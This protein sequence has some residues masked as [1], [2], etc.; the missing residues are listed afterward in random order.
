LI[1]TPGEG[2]REGKSQNESVGGDKKLDSSTK[3]KLNDKPH[4]GERQNRKRPGKGN[5]KNFQ[6]VKNPD[7]EKVYRDTQRGR[8]PYARGARVWKNTLTKTE[9]QASRPRVGRNKEGKGNGQ[10]TKCRPDYREREN[11]GSSKCQ[12]NPN[13]TQNLLGKG[14]KSLGEQVYG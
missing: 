12:K 14:H 10:C 3:G 5:Q 11:K 6:N 2:E 8:Q 9:R 13:S 7:G 4:V 1:K